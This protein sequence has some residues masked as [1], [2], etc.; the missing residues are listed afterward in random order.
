LVKN[1]ESADFQ[2]LYIAVALNG[3]TYFHRYVPYFRYIQGLLSCFSDSIGVLTYGQDDVTLHFTSEDR[4]DLHTKPRHLCV[5]IHIFIKLNLY[6]KNKKCED[7]YCAHKLYLHIP[8]E[9]LIFEKWEHFLKHFL[10]SAP[11][12][13]PNARDHLFS[14]V[15][16]SLLNTVPE[17][18]SRV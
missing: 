18:P 10:N 2:L 14:A 5:E 15:T 9:K 7:I 8:V 16:K 1:S 17:M 12:N 4:T 3:V 13:S 6:G 11:N